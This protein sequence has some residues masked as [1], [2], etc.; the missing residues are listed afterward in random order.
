M[1]SPGPG[2]DFLIQRLKQLRKEKENDVRPRSRRHIG[3]F[4]G[5]T[6]FAFLGIVGI[7]SAIVLVLV[8]YLL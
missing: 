3:P 8:E 1:M 7:V 6:S 5:D 4:G 2:N